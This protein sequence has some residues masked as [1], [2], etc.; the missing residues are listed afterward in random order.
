MRRTYSLILVLQVVFLSTISSQNYVNSPFSRF[1]FGE[2]IEPGFVYNRSLGGT[3][4]ALRSNNQINYINPASYTAFDTLSFMFAAGLTGRYATLKTNSSSDFSRNFNFEYLSLGFPVFKYAKVAAGIRP[5]SRSHYLFSEHYSVDNDSVVINYDG[6]GGF[7]NFF[8]GGAVQLTNFLSVGA[9]VNYLFGSLDRN[10]TLVLANQEFETSSTQQYG[11]TVAGDF[12]YSAGI[13][14]HYPVLPKHNITIGATYDF[15]AN[16][17]LHNDRGTVRNFPASN[18]AYV[19]T[20]SF[21]EDSAGTLTMPA[22]YGIGITYNYDD[23]Y[24]ISFDYEYQDWEQGSYNGSDNNFATFTSYRVGFEYIPVPLSAKSRASYFKRV[25]YRFGAHYSNPYLSIQNN[26][27]SDYG[28]SVGIGLPWRNPRKLYTKTTFNIDY[29][30][31]QKKLGGESAI[32]QTYHNF[33][34]GLTLYDFWFIKPKY[35]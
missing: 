30:F 14:L 28:V 35:D 15:E 3:G 13:Q 20:L 24:K 34:I 2:R 33:T 10:T 12:Y 4:I 32:T 16:I 9:N 7:N 22:K 18:T 19:D 17:R 31:G 23:K 11:N 5:F 6:S 27:L 1:G 29:Q 25:S 21:Y 8:L 26:Q